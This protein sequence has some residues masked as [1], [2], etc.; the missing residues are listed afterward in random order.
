MIGY[1]QML[2]RR[3]RRPLLAHGKERRH[4]RTQAA[5]RGDRP[6]RRCKQE[7]GKLGVTST[8]GSANKPLRRRAGGPGA[9]KTAQRRATWAERDGA[10][11]FLASNYP[12]PRTRTRSSSA[13]TARRPTFAS[14]IAYHYEKFVRRSFDH[15]VN[16]WGVDHQGHVP[17]MAAVMQALGPGPQ[18]L[19]IV[20]LRPGQADPRG[21][22]GQAL[23]TQGRHSQHRRCRGRGRRRRRALQP[24]DARAGKHHRVRPGPGRCKNRRQPGL[25]RAVQPCPHLLDHGQG[26]ESGTSTP[27]TASNVANWR[28]S[29]HPAEL[30]LIRKLLEL[31]EH[32]EL[33][34]EKLSPHNLT[35]Y[36]VDLA[37]TFNGFYR[38]CQVV[39]PQCAGAERARCGFAAQRAR[40]SGLAKTLGR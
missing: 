26:A 23:Q 31:E 35:H 32:I 16:V 12:K 14:D 10:V 29:P 40:A 15:V 34:V 30:A 7:L 28:C 37:R 2:A 36:A 18:R 22:G 9:R 6:R 17:R 5:G 39:D 21:P 25:L 11:W 4:R 8:A 27:A 20:L 33:A 24:A 38:D 19:T 13:P 1:A 3:R